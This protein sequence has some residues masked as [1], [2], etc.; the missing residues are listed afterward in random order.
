MMTMAAAAASPTCIAPA[1]PRPQHQRSRRSAV[2]TH[3]ASRASL[4]AVRGTSHHH[5][6][7]SRARRSPLC[8]VSDSAADAPADAPA[9]DADATVP[10]AIPATNGA[11]AAGITALAATPPPRDPRFNAANFR[12]NLTTGTVTV[13]DPA[14]EAA[15]RALAA[16]ADAAGAAAASKRPSALIKE[17]EIKLKVG[18]HE[19]NPD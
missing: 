2:V 15:K 19:L 17:R 12:V 14:E 1:A 4:G 9:A 8:A 5:S 6:S 11:G 16:E 10:A 13:V 7:G 3:G 18:L